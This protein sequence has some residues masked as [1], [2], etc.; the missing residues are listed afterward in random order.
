M[1]GIY[2]APVLLILALTGIMRAQPGWAGAVLSLASAVKNIDPADSASSPP[3]TCGDTVLDEMAVYRLAQSRYPESGF[4]LLAHPE[5]PDGAYL[6]ILKGPNDIRVMG[7]TWI[8]V[9]R[10]CPRI[11][12]ARSG[13]QDSVGDA[14]MAWAYPIHGGRDLPAGLKGV[15]VI[16]G[17]L[18]TF[19]LITGLRYWWRRTRPGTRS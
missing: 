11:I 10:F 2:L 6:V 1:L 5:R 8:M 13:S 17:L 16:A 15:V 18:P 12:A 4:G 3:G 14:A 9:D 7:D 19:L